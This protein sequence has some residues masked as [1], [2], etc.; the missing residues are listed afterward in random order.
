MD[1]HDVIIEPWISEKSHLMTSE[2]KYTF[3]VGIKANKVQIKEAV[4][5]LFKVKVESV[6]TIKVRGRSGTSWTKM[7][8]IKGKGSRQKKAIV[9]LKEG[10]TIPELTESA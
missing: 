10:F 6:N 5:K 8:R 1:I 9:T 7:R 3:L 4:E 2:G